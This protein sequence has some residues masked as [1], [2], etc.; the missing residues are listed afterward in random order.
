MT[1]E[2]FDRSKLYTMSKERFR[3][4]HKEIE[5]LKE[6]DKKTSDRVRATYSIKEK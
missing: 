6:L 3:E 1:K 5:K 2:T 4:I